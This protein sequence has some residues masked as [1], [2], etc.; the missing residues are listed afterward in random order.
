M[1]WKAG[2]GGVRSAAVGGFCLGLQGLASRGS[3]GQSQLSQPL[4]GRFEEGSG[5]GSDAP[6]DAA[7]LRPA[8]TRPRHTASS[9]YMGRCGW[10]LCVALNGHY[11]SA[12]SE[13]GSGLY[14][15]GKYIYFLFFTLCSMQGKG[16]GG[17]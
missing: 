11:G 9:S 2:E 12:E 16:V 14:W 7:A 17:T 6:T 4:L 15:K 10:P 5:E 1:R 8:A 3:L 13:K